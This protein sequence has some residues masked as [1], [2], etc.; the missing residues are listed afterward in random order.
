[1]QFEKCINNITK[2]LEIVEIWVKNNIFWISPNTYIINKNFIGVPSKKIKH[3]EGVYK[4]K[5]GFI[6]T[7][8]IIGKKSFMFILRL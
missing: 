3:I 5:Q 2:I 8:S 7:K 4:W 6:N 1:M